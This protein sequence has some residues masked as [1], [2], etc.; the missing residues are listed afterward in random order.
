MLKNVLILM[1]DT[2][3]GHRSAAE[4]IAEGLEHIRPGEFEVQFLDFIAD[5]TPFPLNRAA[6]MRSSLSTP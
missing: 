3:G 1:S 2:G 5:C 4:A 6:R